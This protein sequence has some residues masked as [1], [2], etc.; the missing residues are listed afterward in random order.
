MTGEIISPAE[1]LEYTVRGIGDKIEGLLGNDWS[2][3][4]QSLQDFCS[5]KAGVLGGGLST[6]VV[7]GE[8]LAGA[9]G[10]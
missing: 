4:K 8:S 1:L 7:A 3:F 6:S 10:G 9:T 5:G 2:R